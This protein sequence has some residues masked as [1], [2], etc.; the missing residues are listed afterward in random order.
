MKRRYLYL[1]DRMTAPELVNASCEAVTRLD[2]KCIVGKLGTMLVLF[3]G[4]ALP[5]VVL[6]RRLRKV[7][8]A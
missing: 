2:G 8:V 7:G 5:R 4:E 1:G 3:A 6:R